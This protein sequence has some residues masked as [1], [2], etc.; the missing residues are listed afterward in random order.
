MTQP[1][2]RSRRM[3]LDAVRVFNKHVFNK[4]TLAL[5][6]WG[7][8]PFSVLCHVGRQSSRIYRTPVLASYAGDSVIIPL[9]YGH[10]V[11]WLRNVLAHG[12]CEIIWHK[13]TITARDPRVL[14]AGAAL[15]LL[16]P[17]RHRLFERFEIAE[18]LLLTRAGS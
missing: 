4:L 2:R 17:K 11:D 13:Q 16:P 14:E 15:Q 12:G 5:A 10:D 9:S 6:G 1:V 8:G 3:F 18:F 7:K